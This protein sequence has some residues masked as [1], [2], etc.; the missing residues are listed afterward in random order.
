MKVFCKRNYQGDDCIF[1][2]NNWYEL[3][4]NED[5]NTGLFKTEIDSVFIYTG[6]TF[7]GSAMKMG[8]RFTLEKEKHYNL[9]PFCE[10]FYT[11][12]EVRILKLN[13]INEKNQ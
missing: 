7:S 2:K 11:E 5:F 3:S 10:Y 12:K 1:T 4:P 13:K 6:V 8:Y 9:R